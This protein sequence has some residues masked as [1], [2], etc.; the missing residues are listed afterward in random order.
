MNPPDPAAAAGVDPGL[1]GL[2]ESLQATNG[3]PAAPP[4]QG[5]SPGEPG[6]AV[7]PPAVIDWKREARDLW[8]VIAMLKLRWPSLAGVFTPPAIEELAEVWAP[9][10]ER[11]NLDLGKFTIYFAAGMCT[12]PV[13]GDAWHAIKHDQVK[14]DKDQAAAAP[15]APASVAP[16]GPTPTRPEAT[17]AAADA[18]AWPG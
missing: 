1:L 13:L 14:V 17:P 15:P 7:K 16:A 6:G 2:A 18:L 5:G 9:V 8:R 11:H 4:G 3:D 12:A 10:L